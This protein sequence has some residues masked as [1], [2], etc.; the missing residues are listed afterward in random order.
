MSKE[1]LA[2]F[3]ETDAL[4]IEMN[5]VV[6]KVGSSGNVLYDVPR[7]GMHKDRYSALAMGNDYISELEKINIK[8]HRHGT[9]CIGVVSNF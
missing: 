5:N 1:E 9:P 3:L 7:S 2:N 8:Q 6:A 4:Q